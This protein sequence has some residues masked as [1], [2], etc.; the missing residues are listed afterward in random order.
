MKSARLLALALAGA[1]LLVPTVQAEEPQPQAEVQIKAVMA[2]PYRGDISAIDAGAKTFTIKGKKSKERIFAITPTT[3]LLK[4]G[5]PAAWEDLKVGE[6]V[7]GSAVKKSE[8]Q[9]EAMSVKMGA[10]TSEPAN[11]PQ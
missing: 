5:N 6:A 4:D 11:K 8:G 1:F 9:Y 7:R 2:I 3:K 10:K